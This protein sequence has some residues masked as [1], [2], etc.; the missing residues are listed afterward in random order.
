MRPSSLS[1]LMELQGQSM[2]RIFVSAQSGEGL[3][4]LREWLARQVL[5]ARPP[6][7]SEPA[8]DL[9]SGQES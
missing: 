2:H 9:R 3:P 1:D 4:V 6:S 7:A 5:T 8:G